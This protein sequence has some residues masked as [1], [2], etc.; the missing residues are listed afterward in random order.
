VLLR[1]KKE[2][3]FQDHAKNKHPRSYA[4]FEKL[5]IKSEP[6][7]SKSNEQSE[8]VFDIDLDDSQ[9]GIDDCFET[10]QSDKTLE[11]IMFSEQNEKIIIAD[12]EKMEIGEKDKSEKAHVK[13]KEFIHLCNFCNE[14]CNDL[15]ELKSHMKIHEKVLPIAQFAPKQSIDMKNA[16]LKNMSE[17]IK[18]KD[19][20]HMTENK[21]HLYECH[22]GNCKFKTK[23]K[24]MLVI[25]IKS[26][27]ECQ[28]CGKVFNG[29]QAKRN[30]L[31]HKKFHEKPTEWKCEFCNKSYKYNSKLKTHLETCQLKK[32]MEQSNQGLLNIKYI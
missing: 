10:M 19:N 25:H 2:P 3:T 27:N 21:E 17:E 32:K 24:K 15:I 12:N 28:I 5:S 6:P 13:E 20:R 22:S 16:I 8:I 29:S 4:F 14:S 26:H 30:L 11:E 1:Q 7:D 31:S 18:Q 23:Y 9:I